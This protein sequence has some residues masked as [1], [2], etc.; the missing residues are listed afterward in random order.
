MVVSWC[1]TDT[2]II[3]TNTIKI[4]NIEILEETNV[5][6]VVYNDTDKI[7]LKKV[8]EDIAVAYEIY[9]KEERKKDISK[10]MEFLEAQIKNYEQK[11]NDDYSELREYANQQLSWVNNTYPSNCKEHLHENHT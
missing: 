10:S 1:C 7:L 4:L 6:K 5:V 2:P 9:R 3:T 8:L 11:A